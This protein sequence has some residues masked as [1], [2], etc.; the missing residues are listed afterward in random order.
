MYRYVRSFASAFCILLSAGC[1]ADDPLADPCADGCI[2]NDG[3]C[4]RGDIARHCGTAGEMCVTCGEMAV[5]DNTSRV[6]QPTC[7][8]F[9]MQCKSVSD[10]PKRTCGTVKCHDGSCVYTQTAPEGGGCV[11]FVGNNQQAG[12]CNDCECVPADEYFKA[13]Q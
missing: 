2:N 7:G 13:R 11:A 6:C 8:S 5:C 10:C 12:V 4:V 3:I 9:A 1:Y